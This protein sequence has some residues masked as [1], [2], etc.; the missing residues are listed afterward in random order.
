MMLKD[1]ANVLGNLWARDPGVDSL[2]EFVKLVQHEK[3]SP[4]LGCI[5]CRRQIL[6]KHF[7]R[8]LTLEGLVEATRM[9]QNELCLACLT[10]DYPLRN[11]PDYEIL[12]QEL[13]ILK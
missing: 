3:H 6:L 10:G 13:D 9:P 8:I 11:Q 2:L 7:E 1:V 5:E 12:T 4:W